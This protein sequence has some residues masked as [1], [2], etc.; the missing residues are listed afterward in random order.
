MSSPDSTVN[1]KS[2]I[3]VPHYVYNSL[4]GTGVG[5]P[6]YWAMAP[7]YDLT[8]TPYYLS[9][10]GFF[11]EA[12]FRQRL[13]YGSYNIRLSGV[14]Q[15]DPDAFPAPGNSSARG[16]IES[17]GEFY[18]SSKWSI[19]W[20]AALWSDKY[21][22]TNYKI[23]SS[24]NIADYFPESIST[25]YLKGQGDR[26]Y[27]DLRGYYIQ[28]QAASDIQDQIP[29]AAPVLDYNK[30]F[31]LPKDR[32]FGIGGEAT[33]DFNFT[34]LNQGLAAY[35]SVG[36]VPL[37]PVGTT[38]L[39][40][41]PYCAVYA[42]GGCL[43]R[44]IGGNYDRVSAEL[45]WRRN[46]Y[47]PFGGKWQPF[48][49]A[50]IDGTFA[51]IDESGSNAVTFASPTGTTTLTNANQTNWFGGS[52]QSLARAMPGVGVEYRFP[53]VASTSWATHIFEPIAQVV[54]RPNETV[55]DKTINEDSQS[56]V[57]DDTN[58]FEWNKFSG[59]D[60]T[61]GGVRLNAGAQYT[62]HF[63]TTAYVNAL[64]GQS[65]QL[66]G[67]NSYSIA[68]DSNTGL[69]S[70]LQNWRSY[71]ITR[72]QIVPTPFYSLITKANFDDNTFALRRLD[73]A[74]MYNLGHLSGQV[75]Y[76]RYDAQPAI[77]YYYRREGLSLNSRYNFAE[78]YYVNGNIGFDMSRYLLDPQLG[79][80]TGRFSPSSYGLGVG[81]NDDCTTLSVNYNF[82]YLYGSGILTQT[83]SV[84]AQLTLRT[85]GTVRV[86]QSISADNVS[87]ASSQ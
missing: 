42:P 19:G 45:S 8:V 4:L 10:Q 23:T 9:R 58:L 74:G 20:D 12:L 61:E 65:F 33:F 5:V 39:S 13:M 37:N 44:G 76:S 38:P 7:N 46:I 79:T 21:Y 16:G 40:S 80:K 64:A 48:A 1:S 85:L 84:V 25:A 17:K 32:T 57:F 22:S 86:N 87:D 30:A 70:G 43:I 69:D 63:S 82:G 67:R 2:G 14:F 56:L 26:S 31:D 24:T 15:N 29:V 3:L 77:G 55:S 18:L 36:N 73:V 53:L 6:I 71:Y 52:N 28:G 59:Y 83:Q 35:Q 81:Y 54:A 68:D 49:F 66:A 75:M 47:D 34:N 60:R 11:G 27:F 51:S 41:F 50:K 78:H 72:L 62:M